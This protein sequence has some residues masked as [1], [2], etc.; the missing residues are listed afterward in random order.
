MAL[1]SAR[2]RI[3]LLAVAIRAA[4]I[5]FRASSFA[6]FSSCECTSMRRPA[7][8]TLVFL[9]WP[10]SPHALRCHR[11]RVR[12]RCLRAF[13][14]AR[15]RHRHRCLQRLVL[16]RA[17]NHAKR[18]AKRSQT[19]A[20][21]RNRRDRSPRFGFLSAYAP[22]LNGARAPPPPPPPPSFSDA[23]CL[24]TGACLLRWRR[25]FT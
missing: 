3:V 25:V 5:C 2:A 14:G 17:I 20:R 7:L 4:A 16:A 23:P 24:L 11:T 15:R 21:T 19:R 13:F 18:A 1:P 6:P 12:A 8:F 9:A 22:L 10:R